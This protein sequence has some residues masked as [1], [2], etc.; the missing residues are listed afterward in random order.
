[1]GDRLRH[2]DDVWTPKLVGE[3]LV[4]AAKWSIASAGRTGPADDRNGILE[5]LD[6]ENVVPSRKWMLSPARVSLL[7]KAIHWP[8]IYLKGNDGAARVLQLWLRCKCT[9]YRFGHA[10]DDKGWSRATAYRLR[11]KALST[12]S[13]G[14]DRDRIEVPRR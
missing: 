2:Y 5:K 9:R 8:A 11:D 6:P 3:V 14:L 4:D 10:V 1:M 12:I 7:E 13:Q